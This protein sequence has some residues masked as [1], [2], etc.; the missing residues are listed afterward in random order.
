MKEL[1]FNGIQYS[2]TF[3]VQNTLISD[4]MLQCWHAKGLPNDDYSMQNGV[5]TTVGIR[6]LLC[7]EPQHQAVSWIKNVFSMGHLIAK[8]LNDVDVLK[9]LELAI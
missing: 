4:V 8:T 2:E 3:Q 6:F 9:H 7:V 5:L 1:T